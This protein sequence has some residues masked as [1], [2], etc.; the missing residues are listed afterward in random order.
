MRVL[1]LN[2]GSSSLKAGCFDAAGRSRIAGTKVA[3]QPAGKQI[4]AACTA[5]LHAAFA[6]L[7]RQAPGVL[8]GL[9]AIG[10]RIVHGGLA[11]RRTTVIDAG[12]EA[13]I[14]GCVPL[15][16]LHNAVGLA[17]LRAARASWPALPQLAVFDTAFHAQLPPAAWHYALPESLTAP[18]Q[19]RRFGFHGIN[20]AQV[21]RRCAAVLG[22]EPVALRLVSCHLG[23]GASVAA[24]VGGHS[25]DTSMGYTPL[26]GLVMGTRAGDLDP[27]LVLRLAR[28][29]VRG[30]AREHGM[31][32]DAAGAID[33]L[34]E[35]LQRRSGLRALGGTEDVAALESRAAQGDEAATLALDVYVH[36]LRRYIGAMCAST[37]GADA[38][39]FSGGV[40]EHSAVVRSRA[41]GALGWLGAQL[42][43]GANAA[44]RPS[45]GAPVAR[46]STPTSAVSLLVVAADEE[47]AIAEEVEGCLSG[48]SV[49]ESAS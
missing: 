9:D 24:I 38:I 34:E 33:S 46:I 5:A 3:L 41:C 4:A 10:H 44:A 29:A 31:Y 30:A 12:V 11:L 7:E 32:G 13:R 15:A 1:V 26:E 14:E 19:A 28:E 48:R 27:G 36:R 45:E 39:A 42:D 17:M 35:Q 22:V 47:R 40:G 37:G 23:A 21:L 18:L 43:A 6:D 16:P 49:D 8:Q 2:A 20:H 25:V